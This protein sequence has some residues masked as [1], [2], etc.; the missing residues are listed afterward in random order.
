MFEKVTIITLLYLTTM[1]DIKQHSF[2]IFQS[3]DTWFHTNVKVL[4]RKKT[5]Y[6]LVMFIMSIK[7]NRLLV[8]FVVMNHHNDVSF[9]Y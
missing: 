7:V 5:N 4:E 9:L 6:S 2:E 8:M 3:C 1:G